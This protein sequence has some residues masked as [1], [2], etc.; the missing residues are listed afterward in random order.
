MK[1]RDFIQKSTGLAAGTMF[2]G[3]G[4]SRLFGLPNSGRAATM[5]AIETVTLNNGIKM[6]ILGFGTLYLNGDQ[7]TQCVSEAISLGYRLI[8][9]AKVYEN[10]EAVGAGIKK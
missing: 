9:T 5:A 7:G 10:E 4:T 1:R 8:D 3:S 2:L 6:P